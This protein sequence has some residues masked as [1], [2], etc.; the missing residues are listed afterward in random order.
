MKAIDIT[1]FHLTEEDYIIQAYFYIS[2]CFIIE[3][4][5]VFFDGNVYKI[6]GWEYGTSSEELNHKEKNQKM[7]LTLQK[8]IKTQIFF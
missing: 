7:L 8:I 1:S 3:D 6:I 4:Q 5:M 2:P